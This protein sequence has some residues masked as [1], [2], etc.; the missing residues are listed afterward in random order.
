MN[1]LKLFLLSLCFSVVATAAETAVTVTTLSETAAAIPYE[2]VDTTNGN[3]AANLNGDVFFLLY[4]ADA[5]DSA[6]VTFTAQQTSK[7]VAGYGTLTKANLAVTLTALQR[8]MVGPFR[9]RAWN[10]SSGNI[11]FN[12]TGDASGDV[13]V[14]ALRVPAG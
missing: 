6:V 11:I 4:N 13:D 1:Y 2:S 7:T 14:A 5:A 8:Q 12:V 9:S 3:S 10:N